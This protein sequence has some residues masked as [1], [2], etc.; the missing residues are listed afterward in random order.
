LSAN[1]IFTAKKLS[2][3][4]TLSSE[5]VSPFYEQRLYI[6]RTVGRHYLYWGME[7]FCNF[8]Y[9]CSI[10]SRLFCSFTQDNVL[11]PHGYCVSITQRYHAA[12]ISFV[13]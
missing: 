7:C 13:D 1:E 12:L 6:T 11:N 5:V 8:N 3:A 9:N 2:R 10:I 4:V